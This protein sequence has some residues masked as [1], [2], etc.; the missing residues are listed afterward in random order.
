MFSLNNIIIAFFA[1]GMAGIIFITILLSR[2]HKKVNGLMK[3]NKNV[4]PLFLH[5]ATQHKF[6]AIRTK[7]PN[8]PSAHHEKIKLNLDELATNFRKQNICIKTYNEG[9]DN[10]IKQINQHF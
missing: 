10:L 5:K 8:V 9:L 6:N 1:V 3:L 4:E 7:L 2:Q